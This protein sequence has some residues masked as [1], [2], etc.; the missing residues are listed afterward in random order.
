MMFL[1]GALAEMRV[2]DASEKKSRDDHDEENIKHGPLLR[3]DETR[4][5][6]QVSCV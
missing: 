6:D 4:S 3:I 5:K 1:L 2:R